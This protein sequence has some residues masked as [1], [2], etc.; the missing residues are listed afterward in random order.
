MDLDE[1]NCKIINLLQ[2]DCRASLTDI[3]KTVG[4]SVDSTK[5]R[6]DKLRKEKIFFSK[7]QVRP[8]ALGYPYIIDVKLKL[9]NY[10]EKTFHEFVEYVMNHPRVC[11]AFSIS[12]E[13]NFSLVMMAKDHEDLARVCDEV[14]TKYSSIISDWTESLT[15]VAY[16]FEKYDL[17]KLREYEKNVQG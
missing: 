5:K 8:R 7:V 16:K 14:K 10:S 2:E 1:I 4:L 12:G 11:E 9:R 17:M 6:I 3:A 15:T 13:W